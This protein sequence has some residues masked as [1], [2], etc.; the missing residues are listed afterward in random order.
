MA[1]FTVSDTIMKYVAGEMNIGQAIFIRGLFATIVIGSI[2]VATG[3]LRISRQALHPF[4]LLRVAA[5]TVTT[6]AYLVALKHIPLGDTVAIFQALP[7]AVTLGAA[8]FLK[9]YVGWRRWLAIAFGFLGVLIVA[10]PGGG[11]FSPYAI[12]LLGAVATAA[13]R[14]LLI[15]GIPQQIPATVISFVNSCSVMAVGALLVQPFGGWTPPAAGSIGALALAAAMLAIGY[16]F[17]ILSTRL[18]DVSF[19]APFRYTSLMWGLLLG[20]LVFGEVPDA[21]MLAGAS[22]ILASGLY[23]LHRER[24]VRRARN[25]AESAAKSPPPGVAS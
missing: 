10:G 4:V 6:F 13:A 25:A 1:V 16:Q 18:G 5:D 20:A 22:M 14:D 2:G 12:L 19:I 24:V 11:G 9:E 3:T 8:L 21:A 23:T 7:V 17:F 15:R